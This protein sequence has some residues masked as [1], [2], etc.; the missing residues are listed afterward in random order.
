MALMTSTPPPEPSAPE[1]LAANA[2]DPRNPQSPIPNEP[3]A[4]VL[5]PTPLTTEGLALPFAGELGGL[6]DTARAFY[7]RLRT[8]VAGRFLAL[9]RAIRSTA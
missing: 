4:S 7:G 2:P 6:V 8:R 3:S 5:F 9:R 1:T